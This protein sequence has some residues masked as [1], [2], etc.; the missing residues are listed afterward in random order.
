MIIPIE[1]AKNLLIKIPF[2]KERA[3]K[4]HV[5]GVNQS[6]EGIN[7]ILELYKKYTDFENKDVIELGPGHTYGVACKIKEAGAKS[8]SI[9]DI[10]KYITDKVLEENKDLN[11]II[12]DGNRM[13]LKDESHDVVLSY[14]VFEH[15]RNPVVTVKE[16]YRIL[17]KGGVA[18]HLIDMG[19]HMYYGE[20]GNPDRIFDCMR[21]S[22]FIWNAM[23]INRSTFVN[24]LRPSEWVD[25]HKQTG[26]EVLKTESKDNERIKSLF[27]EGKV[28]YLAKLKPDDRFKS[29]LLIVLK[30]R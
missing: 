10:E 2:I 5:T 22:E 29:Y 4:K 26:F 23:S 19:D 16:T 8:I 30:K 21:Y 7:M 27:E 13:P 24:R 1:I 12:Y 9:I 20:K 17:R 25:M 15:L 3:K 11:Y 28:Q 18:V 6:E 14:T